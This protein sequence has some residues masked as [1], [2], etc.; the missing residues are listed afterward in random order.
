MCSG[1][2]A[3]AAAQLGDMR[4]SVIDYVIGNGVSKNLGQK[5]LHNFGN[6]SGGLLGDLSRILAF[7]IVLIEKQEI[8]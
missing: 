4:N 5:I 7:S 2:A 3:A 8:K 1:E 6:L